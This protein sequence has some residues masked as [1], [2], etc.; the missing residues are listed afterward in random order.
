MREWSVVTEE[1][2]Q[3]QDESAKIAILV[4]DRC[5][6]QDERQVWFSVFHQDP[7]HMVSL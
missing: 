4:V 2:K 6:K 5:T 3:W 7:C 1:K